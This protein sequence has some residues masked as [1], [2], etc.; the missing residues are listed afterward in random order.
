M[1]N[2]TLDPVAAEAPVQPLVAPSRLTA[3][4]RLEFRRTALEALERAT[5]AG[6][7]PIGICLSQS[8]L[9]TWGLVLS[10]SDAT[11]SPFAIVGLRAK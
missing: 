8:R 2:A 7:R 9:R 11:T 5:L 4:H 6:A 1:T 3:D 10:R